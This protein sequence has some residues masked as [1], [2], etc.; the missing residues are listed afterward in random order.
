MLPLQGVQV[1]YQVRE[2]RSCML[3]SAA[4]IFFS[5]FYEENYEHH[6]KKSKTYIIGQICLQISL[7]LYFWRIL[8]L[9]LKRY[10][11][12]AFLISL[13]GFGIRVTLVSKNEAGS[14]HASSVFWKTFW[15]IGGNSLNILVEFTS[16]FVGFFLITD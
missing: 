13:S 16:C 6:W 4:K 14:G 15:K 11:S 9:V 1:W 8:Y 7:F 5:S 10:W 3:C 2:L 12:I